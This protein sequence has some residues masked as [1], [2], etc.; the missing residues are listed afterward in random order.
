MWS[1]TKQYN[2]DTYEPDESCVGYP[3]DV[4]QESINKT[5][6]EHLHL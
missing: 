3:I 2:R 1:V 4:Y 5:F 6:R